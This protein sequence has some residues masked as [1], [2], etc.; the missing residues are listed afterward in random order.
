MT[1]SPWFAI[2]FI[3]IVPV[4]CSGEQVALNE[5]LF[6]LPSMEPMGGGCTLFELGG[7]A[8]QSTETSALDLVVRQKFASNAAIVDV[9]EGDRVVVER[10]YDQS[11]FQSGT[12]D[13][14]VAQ[15][16]TGGQL[17]LRYWGA[18]HPDGTAGCA[19]LSD[20]GAR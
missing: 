8:P 20:D 17:L 10:Q 6:A 12:V 15:S 19:E 5:R 18:F 14:F 7:A 11:F 1:T 9:E 2:A 4:A 13:E 16:N 3:A